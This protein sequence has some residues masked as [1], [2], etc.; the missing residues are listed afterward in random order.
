MR[1]LTI[2]EI[3]HRSVYIRLINT[4]HVYR[5]N[6]N[7]AVKFSDILGLEKDELL[8]IGVVAGK[9]SR[10]NEKLLCQYNS[11]DVV[12]AGDFRIKNLN[13]SRDV[14]FIKNDKTL[15]K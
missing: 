6:L 3:S 7:R 15:I 11:E 9:V 1:S 14:T 5:I 4:S 10:G 12:V 13:F 2:E 8:L